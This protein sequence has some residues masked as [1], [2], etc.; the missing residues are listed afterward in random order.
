M[1]VKSPKDV[2]IHVGQAVRA[3]RKLMKISQTELAAAAGVSFQ[4]VQ[5]YENAANRISCSTL[6]VFAAALKC[7]PQDLLPDTAKPAVS[8]DDPA[9]ELAG[10]YGGRRL[11]QAYLAMH[12]RCQASLLSVASALVN[13]APEHGALADA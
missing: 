4:Q 13:I 12:P 2:D 1:S 11:A 6:I 10:A 9:L 3:R 8:I 5:K 7:A